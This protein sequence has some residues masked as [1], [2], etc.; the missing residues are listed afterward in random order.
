MNRTLI[1]RLVGLLE[2]SSLSEIEHIVDGTR[3]RLVKRSGVPATTLPREMPVTASEPKTA[4]KPLT[5][6][7]RAGLTGVFYHAPSSDEPPFITLGDVVEEGQPLAII[8][9][10]K[11]LNV[12]EADRGGKIV[13]IYL[14][15]GASVEAGAPLFELQALE[16]SDV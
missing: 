5:H 1:D 12:L 10:M 16:V 14:E 6:I 9:A 15:D 4:T 8:E 2:S 11:M 3:I 7:I 13:Q